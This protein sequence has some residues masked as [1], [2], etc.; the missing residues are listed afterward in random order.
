MMC[1]EIY[2][3][4]TV[5]HEYIV[6]TPGDKICE[7]FSDNEMAWDK[8]RVD[9]IEGKGQGCVATQELPRGILDWM[10]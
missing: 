6:P 3:Q 10:G 5:D 2:I 1:Q 8:F 4:L 7:N 9:N